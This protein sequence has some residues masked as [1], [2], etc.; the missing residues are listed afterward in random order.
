MSRL[1]Q[2]TFKELVEGLRD[3]NLPAE[4]RVYATDT[5][6]KRRVLLKVIEPGEIELPDKNEVIKNR[7]FIN[8]I[9][10]SRKTA[11]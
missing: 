2:N 8:G 7:R 9:V 1:M 3:F 4:T 6:W 5:D 11:R 10:Q